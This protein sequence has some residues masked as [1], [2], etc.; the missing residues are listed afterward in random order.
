MEYISVREFAE[1]HG[2]AERTVRNY[3]ASGKIE[4]AF[5]MGKTWSIPSDA[6]L[7]EKK[8]IKQKQMPL[9][10]TLQEEKLSG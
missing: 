6:L 2:V 8:R 1:R 5:L 10:A 9:L 7:P 3:C 4:G